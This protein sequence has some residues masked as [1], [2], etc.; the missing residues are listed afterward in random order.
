MSSPYIDNAHIIKPDFNSDYVGFCIATTFR[1]VCLHANNI[2]RVWIKVWIPWVEALIYS[3]KTGSNLIPALLFV[4]FQVT[5]LKFSSG[6]HTWT[7]PGNHT[8]SLIKR[9][10]CYFL[11][12]SSLRQSIPTFWKK[13]QSSSVEKRF[14]LSHLASIQQ[15]RITAYPSKPG[16][17]NLC[18]SINT[19]PPNSPL[20]SMSMFFECLQCVRHSSRH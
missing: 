20:H 4:H 14:L 19:R 15:Y 9:E 17:Y 3:R 10:K 5:K 18:L 16:A 1:I 2:I 6:N 12:T 8:W 11:A 7:I 13:P